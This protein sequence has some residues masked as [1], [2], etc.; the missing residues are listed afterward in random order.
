MKVKYDMEDKV[1]ASI[2]LQ[3]YGIDVNN[4]LFI[5][6]GT[7]AYS[8]Q[9]TDVKGNRFYLKMFDLSNERQRQSTLHM[10][11]YL[12]M[13]W[14]MYHK[15]IF[16]NLCYPI[17]TKDGHYTTI[18]KNLLLVMFNFIDGQPLKDYSKNTILKMAK[19]LAKLHKITP[20]IEEAC[21]EFFHISI[22]PNLM[23]SLSVL[24]STSKFANP[25]MNALRKLVLPRKKEMI[26]Y[27]DL[28]LHLQ[29]TVPAIQQERVLCH[30]D[31]WLGNIIR[32]QDE[33]ILIDWETSLIAPLE[34]DL[35]FYIYK[36]IEFET[37]LKSYENHLGK[38]VVLYLDLIR[39]YSYRRVLQNLT[40]SIWRILFSNK[41]EVE[42]QSDLEKVKRNLAHMDRLELSIQKA[43][44][45]LGGKMI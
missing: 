40:S 34:R 17:Q 15:G 26:K 37:F 25:Y 11:I 43:K 33:F 14:K 8:Y 3:E 18:D 22:Q 23:Q 27:H 13:V 4:I 24:E 2:L 35:F 28:L 29:S 36:N 38:E 44:W 10:D 30:G 6:R 5:P 45:K 41:A 42:Y 7:S 9:V 16:R 21:H 39:F 32:Q 1:L 31:L 20:E 12:P 19:L